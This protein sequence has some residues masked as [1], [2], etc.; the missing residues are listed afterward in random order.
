[1][2]LASLS[3]ALVALVVVSAPTAATGESGHG[4]VFGMTTPT[5][6]TG[7]WAL[8][9]GVMGRSGEGRVGLMTRVMATY[10]VTE[11]LQISASAPLVFASA[12]FAAARGTA[13]MPAN[14]DLEAIGAWR[15][16]RRGTAV[17]TRVEST[18]Y[19]GIIV[20]G[21]QQPAGV[22]GG[23]KRA[24]G[25][26]VAGA[27][28]LASRSHYVWAGVGYTRFAERSGDRRADVVSYS[29][30]WGYRPPALR[31]E[32]PHWDWRLF[33]ELTGERAS[34]LRRADM[35][36]DG[37]AGHQIFV[38]PTALGI[39]RNYAI[40]GGVQFPVYRKLGAALRREAI[41]YAVNLSYFF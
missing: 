35:V 38:G 37:T 27:T 16:H 41:R 3:A 19:A 12:P 20:P 34:D 5:N 17:G 36:Q 2:T 11:D 7:A 1:M 6:A 4:P 8:D 9:F 39:L 23:L 29:A 32:Y 24:P 22:V 40:E 30:V 31:T 15:F 26:Y 33:V 13:M 18:A 21:P 25:L 14:G 28:G 10:G